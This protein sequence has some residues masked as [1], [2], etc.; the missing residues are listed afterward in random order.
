MT[1][2]QADLA[3]KIDAAVDA[4]VELLNT[5]TAEQIADLY[6]PDA[7]VE[8]PIGADIR[9]TREQLV[10]FYSVITGMDER[11]ATLKW[12]KVAGDTAVFE[13]TLVTKTAGL[14]FEITPVDIMV[15]NAD[16]KVSSM[17]AVWRPEDLT[18][19]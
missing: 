11:T 4:Y 12:K 14:A 16:G 1:V 10:E 9:N 19:L 13:F 7:T 3:D 8:D 18:Q 2:E 5:G 6:A 17:R 15:F